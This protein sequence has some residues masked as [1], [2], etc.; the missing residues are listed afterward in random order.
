ML[1]WIGSICLSWISQHRVFSFSLPEPSV[2][3][4]PGFKEH[5]VSKLL[6]GTN[7]PISP[8]QLNSHPRQSQSPCVWGTR[9][10][11]HPHRGTSKEQDIR[12]RW[13]TA[14]RRVNDK[15][16]PR[17]HGALEVTIRWQRLSNPNSSVT[18]NDGKTP[19]TVTR[20]Q[21]C[22]LPSWGACISCCHQDASGFQSV[23]AKLPGS[24]P[25]SKCS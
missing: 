3:S 25:Y 5:V 9:R 6:S 2:T 22:L 1:V 10:T 14:A 17:P 20:R 19:A 4:S 8:Q 24:L 15:D 23:A 7:S 11:I 21:G 18:D 16:C 13:A 12:D